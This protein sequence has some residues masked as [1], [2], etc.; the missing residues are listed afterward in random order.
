M[1]CIVKGMERCKRPDMKPLGPEEKHS[2]G[3][4]VNS[5]VITHIRR[6]KIWSK[7][8]TK[9]GERFVMSMSNHRVV[10]LRL[11]QYYI[12]TIFQLKKEEEVKPRQPGTRA[13][14]FWCLTGET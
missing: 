3:N 2:P 4:P 6:A 1:G 12:S 14:E 11:V 13:L 7:D 10:H 5:I 9:C 8:T